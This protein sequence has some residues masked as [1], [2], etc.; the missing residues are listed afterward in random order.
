MTRTRDDLRH[1]RFWR[2]VFS[3]FL[4]TMLYVI[5]GCGAWTENSRVPEMTLSVRVALAFGLIYAVIIYCV[6]N[7]TDAHLNP[8]ITLAM[9]VTRR[10]C[11]LRAILYIVAQFLGAI[12]G[13]ALLYGLTAREYLAQLGCTIPGDEVSDAQGFGIELFSTF[14]LVFVVF[15]A[16]EKSK[17]EEAI[18][19]P[20]IIGIALAAVSMFAVSYL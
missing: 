10:M 5:V 9:L 13:A 8:S 7:V 16:Y 11:F 2:A 14:I 1:L 18:T 3:E 19:A 17:R 12:L 4:G 6:R 20:F 15:A